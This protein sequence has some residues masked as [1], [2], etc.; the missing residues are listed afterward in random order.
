[1]KKIICLLAFILLLAPL[2]LSLEIQSQ[3]T[4]SQGE[5]ALIKISGNF[6][7]PI[8]DQNVILYRGN[9]K[10]GADISVNKIEDEYYLAVSLLDKTPGKYSLK[11]TGAT[12]LEGKSLI[13][14]PI[15][16]D[17]NV[18]SGKVDFSIL[19]GAIIT[20]DDFTVGVQNLQNSKIYVSVSGWDS[21]NLFPDSNSFEIKSGEIKQIKFTTH[22][23]ESATL[24]TINFKSNNYSY[25][26]PIYI[27]AGGST[28]DSTNA[29]EYIF[30]PSKLVINVSTGTNKTYIAYLRNTGDEDLNNITLELSDELKPYF[31][32]SVNETSVLEKNSSIRVE[33]YVASPDKEVLVQG[34]IKALAEPTL[35]SYLSIDFSTISAY[36]PING[37]Q[38]GT[39]SPGLIND[40]ST[41]TT[42][43]AQSS[44]SKIIGWIIIIAL[45]GFIGWFFFKKYARAGNFKIDL[46]KV[47]KGK[48]EPLTREIILNNKRKL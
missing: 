35:Y 12:Y 2:A 17:F 41:T 22:P 36:I 25:Y 26:L 7:A 37:E 45:L 13:T 8:L 40:T 32:L 34:R 4:Y 43:A 16:V 44:T 33:I 9:A 5:T 42:V 3:E 10:A 19:P 27:L 11:I 39:T 6:V 18:S 30:D 21:T 47:A 23:G 38:S 28:S 24:N 48:E 15:S 29:R 14:E 1:M 46:L 20:K 31:S